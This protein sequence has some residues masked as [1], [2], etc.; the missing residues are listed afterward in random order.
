MPCGAASWGVIFRIE[1]PYHADPNASSVVRFHTE[2]RD[3]GPARR[4]R[5]SWRRRDGRR[6]LPR[7]WV[8]WWRLPGRWLW[9]RRLRRLQGWLCPRWVQSLQPLRFPEPPSHLVRVPVLQQFLSDRLRLRL[10]LP[11]LG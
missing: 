7:R 11:L 4:R 8:R 2:L 10:W 1:G 3:D 6:R 5:R 9:G